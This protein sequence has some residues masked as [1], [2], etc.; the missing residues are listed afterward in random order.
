MANE[1]DK[2]VVDL[3]KDAEYEA[4]L[5][6]AK[7]G[8]VPVGGVPMP[9]M[10]RF[11]QAPPDRSQGVQQNVPGAR[12]IPGGPLLSAQ[13]RDEMAQQG[14]YIP[15]VGSAYAANQPAARGAPVT[16]QPPQQPPSGEYVN[17]PRP[18]GSGL[19]PETLQQLEA[20]A[21][22]NRPDAPVSKKEAADLEET[23]KEMTE[24][25]NESFDYDNFGR[26]V[27]SM[28]NNKERREAIE[29][30]CGAMAIED[31][32]TQGEVRQVVPIIPNKFF[33]TFRSV[34]GVEDLFI[35][36]LM[37]SER[38]SDQYILDK[39][40]IMNLSAGLYALNGKP[41]PSHL[42]DK[43]DPDEKLF[44]H[45][46]KVVLKM[47]LPLIA[48]LSTNYTWFGSRLEKLFIVDNIKGF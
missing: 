22:A 37:S 12:Q 19:R 46:F 7:S 34:Q 11:D 48:D 30:R 14:N 4:R 2:G 16:Q 33:P 43:G 9:P 27:R 40:A 1:K 3:T 45:K 41:L 36:R 17:P 21:Q 38:G 31:L 42:N 20:V 15:G 5:A 44:E 18:E 13:Q 8:R 39:F 29:K 23:V 10:P 47:A 32:I 25:Y 24:D 35:K 28:L 6:A 26:R